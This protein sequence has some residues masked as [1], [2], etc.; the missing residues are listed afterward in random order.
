MRMIELRQV[1]L[2]LLVSLSAVGV[3]ACSED[4]YGDGPAP[5]PTL[6]ATATAE[7]AAATAAALCAAS[8]PMETPGV[9]ASADLVEIS[10][11][12]ASRAYTGLIWAHNDSGDTARVFAMDIR[13][14]H[15]GAFTLA[16]AEAIDWEDMAIGPGPQ[17]GV[18]YLYLADIGDN[19]AQRPEVHIYRVPEPAVDADAL[20]SAADLSGVDKL[21][22]RYPDRPHDA[23]VLLVDPA[24]GDVLI[25]TK[26]IAGGPSFVFRAPGSV[27]TG[28]A[29]VLELV[30]EIPFPSFV[31]S[32]EIPADASALVRGVGHLPTGGDIS[33]DGGLVAIRT[34]ATIWVW[35]RA[36]GTTAWDA[37]SETPCEAPSS[38]EA[39]GE[40]LAFDADGRGYL[41]VSEGPNQP[42]HRFREP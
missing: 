26:E 3:L 34:Y 20:A 35:P 1:W 12:A 25:I 40:A 18:D 13:G 19:Q 11:L 17:A 41:T 38:I 30:A 22:L 31:S 6:E 37:F 39:Q 36:A 16:G 21:V 9:V 7:D 4:Q 29:F 27:D 10:G 2:L 24:T 32:T 14:E 33:P 8:P 15:L 23:E 42:L 5:S 28:T